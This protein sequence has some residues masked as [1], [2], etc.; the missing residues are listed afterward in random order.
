MCTGSPGL[1]QV[2]T[3]KSFGY[4]GETLHDIHQELADAI[5]SEDFT[6]RD[7][8]LFLSNFDFRS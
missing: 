5:K 2:L 7:L 8:H 1:V 6:R 3:G 4:G